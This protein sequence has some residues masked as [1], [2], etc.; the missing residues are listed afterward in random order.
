MPTN[1]K[2][3]GNSVT[4]N[5]YWPLGEA[6]AEGHMMDPMD[7]RDLSEIHEIHEILRLYVSQEM[8]VVERYAQLSV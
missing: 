7:L 6:L 2:R 8:S 1:A 3:G 4:T 5:H